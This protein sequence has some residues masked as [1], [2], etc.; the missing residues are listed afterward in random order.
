MSLWLLAM[1]VNLGCWPVPKTRYDAKT[2]QRGES[3]THGEANE[4]HW[5]DLP[6]FSTRAFKGG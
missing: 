6:C 4:T 5:F 1:R 3:P 2:G